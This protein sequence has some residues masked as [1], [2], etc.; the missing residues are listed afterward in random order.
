MNGIYRADFISPI[1]SGSGTVIL[2]DGILRGGDAS[3]AYAGKY[4]VQG[5]QL[6]AELTTIQHGPGFSILGNATA[7]AIHGNAASMGFIEATG[8]VQNGDS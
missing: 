7:L 3:I 4:S 2:Q 6:N 5:T 1:G 8:K